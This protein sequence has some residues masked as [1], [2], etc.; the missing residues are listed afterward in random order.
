LSENGGLPQFT[1]YGYAALG[2]PRNMKIP[3]NTKP[4]YYDMGLCGPQRQDLS[5]NAEY[6]GLFKVPS[7]RN[8]ALKNVFYHNA[9]AT[10][11]EAAVRFYAERDA[12]PQRWYPKNAAGH[13]RKFNDIPVKYQGNMEDESPFG[14]KR[15]KP[16]LSNA[17]VKDIVAF[18]KTLTDGYKP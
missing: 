10:D 4:R 5:D 7:L 9:A 13:V 6:C 18:L 11:L 15:G 8:V 14:Q 12:Y 2:L 16:D 17:D 1:D 3:A